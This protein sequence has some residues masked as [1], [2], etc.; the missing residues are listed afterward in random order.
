MK[1]AFAALGLLTLAACSSH[2][3]PTESV[4]EA[5]PIAV[6]AERLALMNWPTVQE[7]MGT[8]EA[9]T[10]STVAAQVTGV[11]RQVHAEVGQSVRAGQV[12]VSLEA[13]ELGATLAQAE[14]A[15]AETLSVQPELEKAIEAA[16]VQLD[17]ATTSHQRIAELFAKKSVSPQERDESQARLRAAQAALAMA[18]SRRGQVSARTETAAQGVASAK[19]MLSYLTVA[20]PFDGVVVEKIAQAGSLA[21]PGAPLLVVERAGGYQLAITTDESAQLRLHQAVEVVTGDGEAFQTKVTEIVPAI[22]AGTRTQTVKAALPST[23]AWRSG[24]FA[25]ARWT[26]G[27]RTA[28]TVPASALILHGQLQM[29]LVVESERLR[30]RMVT[31]GANRGGR[32]EMLSGVR[33]GDEVVIQPPLEWKDGAPARV[34]P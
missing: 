12:L 2:K 1:Y 25:R 30:S 20:A 16:R 13:R 8:V 27:E 21:V 19:V 14:A 23:H 34:Q 6:K 22:D 11:I 24:R 28:L 5:A 10:R 15:R 4:R 33:A 26:T 29:V 17:L 3:A 9:R 18:E 32:I 7:A 31:A